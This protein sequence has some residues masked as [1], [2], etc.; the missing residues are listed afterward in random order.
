M[1]SRLYVLNIV[2]VFYVHM[3]QSDCSLNND[4]TVRCTQVES[5]ARGRWI[6]PIIFTNINRHLHCVWIVRPATV[7]S[8]IYC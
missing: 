6:V 2:G 1:D 7:E 8:S 5:I 3:D 4:L